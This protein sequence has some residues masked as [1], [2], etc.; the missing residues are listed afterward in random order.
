MR[1]VVGYSPS[2][3]GRDA[4]N[5]AVALASSLGA[6]L[7]VVYVLK[8]QNPR[9][10]A[11]RSNFGAMLQEQAVGWLEEAQQW[12]PTSLKARFHLRQAES[13]AAG[14]MEFAEAIGAGAIVVG[15]AKTGG[16]L[17]HSLGSVDNALL[18]RSRIPVILAPHDYSEQTKIGQIDCAVSAEIDSISLIEE[19]VATANRTGLPVRLVSLV[20]GEDGA[21]ARAEAEAAVRELLD[22]SSVAP[23]DSSRVS[24]AVGVGATVPDAVE[25][26]AWSA[27]SVLMA[28]SSKLAQ[29]GELFL[30]SNTAKILT[31]L[32]VPLVVVP[33]DYSPG[34]R[35]SA[36][37][38]WTGSIPVVGKN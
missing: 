22:Q 14:L 1:Y 27:G 4:I 37:E 9:L 26:V 10:A 2:S 25:S 7:D 32:P 11:P 35:G 36:Q 20:E 15:G 19:A 21:G 12:V 30:S 13:T 16:W 34:R 23:A 8:H 28:G 33:R 24:V 6:E 17:F 38:P 29:R 5:L 31:R 3:R 18:H